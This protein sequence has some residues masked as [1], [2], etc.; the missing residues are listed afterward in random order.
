MKTALICGVSG[1]D[2]AYLAK[3]LLEKGYRVVDT[4]AR[5]PGRQLCQSGSAFDHR[6][7]RAGVDGALRFSQHAADNYEG[8][9]RRSVQLSRP[10]LRGAVVSPASRNHG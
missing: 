6:S 8:Q 4:S 7:R 2:G 10:E 9:T 5:R 1:Q 3:L